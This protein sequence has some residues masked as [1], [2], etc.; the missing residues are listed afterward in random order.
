MDQTD[1]LENCTFILK[2]LDYCN[3]SFKRLFKLF[4]FL[5]LEKG[6]DRCV[7]EVSSY[8]SSVSK[9]RE[10]YHSLK[11]LQENSTEKTTAVILP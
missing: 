6:K 5:F 11:M 2:M 7:K 10:E 4:F 9:N 1:L 8:K 3:I